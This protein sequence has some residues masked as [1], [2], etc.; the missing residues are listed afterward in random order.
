MRHFD[1]NSVFSS[2]AAEASPACLAGW[3]SRWLDFRPVRPDS[4]TFLR[5]LRSLS[6]TRVPRYYGRSDS[7]RPG[8][9]AP[10]GSMNSVSVGPQVSLSHVLDLPS[11]PSPTT[12][13]PSTSISHATPH[14]VESPAVAGLGFTFPTQAGRLS[15]RIEFL[16]VRMKR[17]PPAAPHPVSRR[18]SSSWLQAGERMP[19]EDFHLSDQARFQAHIGRP[20]K[21]G[22][23]VPR[24]EPAPHRGAWISSTVGAC[25]LIRRSATAYGFG[26]P[27]PALK[28][29]PTVRCRYAAMSKHPG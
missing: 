4:S 9:S 18:R 11:P 6:V 13:G 27:R 1:R 5:S 12:L 19:E 22:T 20:F 23:L 28:G 8:S 26:W 29:R 16:I 2:A 3:H 10:Y 24:R 17:S 21:A 14:L 15:G 25:H 7:C